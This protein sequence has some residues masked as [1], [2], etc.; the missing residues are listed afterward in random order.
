MG[1][2]L[3]TKYRTSNEYSSLYQ[4]NIK[5]KENLDIA[6]NSIHIFVC[7]IMRISQYRAT[8]FHGDFERCNITHPSCPV[9]VS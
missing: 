3:I 7:K 6:I 8:E 4:S 9:D 2:A 5:K 1:H